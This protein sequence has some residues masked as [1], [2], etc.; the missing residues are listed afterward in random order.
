MSK[1]TVLSLKKMF[2]LSENRTEPFFARQKKGW[3]IINEFLFLQ[4]SRK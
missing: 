3:D 1:Q 4:S 2:Y